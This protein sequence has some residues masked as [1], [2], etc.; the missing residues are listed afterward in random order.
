MSDHKPVMALFNLKA[1]SVD[2][3]QF[4][5]TVNQAS[6][7]LDKLENASLPSVKINQQQLQFGDIR[8][9]SPKTCSFVIENTGKVLYQK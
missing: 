8:Y 3:H 4:E 5:K 7:E 1:R 9:R 6:R 2:Y